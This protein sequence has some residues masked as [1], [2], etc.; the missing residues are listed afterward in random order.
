[1]RGLKN[2]TMKQQ[3]I[4]AAAILKANA[5][6]LPDYKRRDLKRILMVLA[7]RYGII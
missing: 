3:L 5:Y 4:E 2:L 6:L 7:V 1:M